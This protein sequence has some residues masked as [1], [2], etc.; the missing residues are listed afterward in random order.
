MV[1]TRKLM[2]KKS[3]GTD[4]QYYPETHVVAVLGLMELL[5]K[6]QG[7][8]GWQ[9]A[10]NSINGKT[11]DVFI[12][13]QDLGIVLATSTSDG[14]LSKEMYLKIQEM[15]DA[16]NGIAVE[17][18]ENGIFKLLYHDV[19]FYPKTNIA[20]VDGLDEALTESGIKGEKGDPGE[21]GPPGTAENL[22]NATEQSDG[23]M[24][25]E[26]KTQLTRLAKYN[27]VNKGEI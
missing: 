5:K 12:T 15:N 10:V 21:Q 20:A 6:Y 9:S 24:S 22:A 14:L 16:Q 19:I 11:G 25:S 23:L 4:E 17:V 1:E 3:D 13:R 27:F 7:E 2:Q 18:D 8:A 26:D